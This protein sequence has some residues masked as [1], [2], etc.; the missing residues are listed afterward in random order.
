MAEALVPL[1]YAERDG[2]PLELW[3]A[4]AEVFDL[5]HR[6]GPPE[7]AR[8]IDVLAFYLSAV[9]LTAPD[10]ADGDAGYL[11]RHERFADYFRRGALTDTTA[12]G[13]GRGGSRLDSPVA[14]GRPVLGTDELLRPA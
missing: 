10:D 9:P 3:L 6:I 13:D 11:L 12:V 4:A 1:A 14:R 2:L 8:A 5:D 7:V